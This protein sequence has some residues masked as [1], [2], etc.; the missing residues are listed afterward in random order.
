MIEFELFSSVLR[1]LVM[2]RFLQCFDTF[3]QLTVRSCGILTVLFDIPIEK[4]L[5]DLTVFYEH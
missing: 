4:L 3:G 5:V 2:N 1:I